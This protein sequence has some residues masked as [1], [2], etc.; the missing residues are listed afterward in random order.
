[1]KEQI[2]AIIS[3]AEY[4]KSAYFF[5]PPCSASARRSYEK[6][7]SHAE[8]TWFEGGHKYT[9]EYSVM[10][11]CSNVYANGI[12][13]KDGKKTTLKAIKN[14]FARMLM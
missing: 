9:A 2:A 14:S 7:H 12:Y 3:E 8:V 10:C 11:S 13:T 1:M 4:M 6:K 5:R